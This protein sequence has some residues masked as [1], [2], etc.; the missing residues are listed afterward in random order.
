M[1]LDETF[2]APVPLGLMMVL[3]MVLPVV[4]SLVLSMVL[5]QTFDI[6]AACS[7]LFKNVDL[8]LYVLETVVSNDILIY[9]LIFLA[10][11]MAA[12]NTHIYVYTYIHICAL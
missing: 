9:L 2:G 3:T 4:L 1:L 6:V 10:I 5:P 12:P 7:F 8:K 11:R